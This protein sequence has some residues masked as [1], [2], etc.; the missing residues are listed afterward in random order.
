MTHLYTE[1]DGVRMKVTPEIIDICDR[2]V[3]SAVRPGAEEAELAEI[4]AE[5]ASYYF[6][7]SKTLDET[8]RIIS[9][10]AGMYLAERDTGG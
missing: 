2:L 8:V 3:S 6:T 5:E 10:R 4:I 9:S 1:A 7:G